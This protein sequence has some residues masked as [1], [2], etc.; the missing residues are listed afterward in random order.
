MG[1]APVD[2]EA[3]LREIA[4]LP[5]VRVKGLMTIAPF[6]DNAETNRVYFAG[7]RELMERLNRAEILDHEMRE[8]SMGMSGDYTVAI[9]EGATLIRVGTAI[10]GARDYT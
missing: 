9:E 8:L 5:H 2:V 3:V 10:F 1:L 6:T 7:L 4:P